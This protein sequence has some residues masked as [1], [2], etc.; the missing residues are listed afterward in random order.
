[1][2][3]LRSIPLLLTG[4]GA[5]T[6]RITRAEEID[7]SFYAEY[8]TV[9]AHPVS[10]L[11]DAASNGVSRN[12][13]G[14]IDRFGTRVADSDMVQIGT[15]TDTFYNEAVGTHPG[16]SLSNST[17]TTPLFQC[18]DSSASVHYLN[19][20]NTTGNERTRLLAL[21]SDG[22][23][24]ELDSAQTVAFGKR[25][26]EDSLKSERLNAFRIGTSTPTNGTWEIWNNSAFKDTT[27]SA[28]TNYHVYRKTGNSTTP[29]LE[30]LLGLMD[31]ADSIDEGSSDIK[32]LEITQQ[33]IALS[34]ATQLARKN[35]ELGKMVLLPSAQ[36]PANTGETGTWQ[37]RGSAIDTVNTT[38]DI[39]Y[40]SEY[41]TS[42]SR[43]EPFVGT[44]QFVNRGSDEYIRYR[45]AVLPDDFVGQRNAPY[46]GSRTNQQNGANEQFAGQ[47]FTSADYAGQRTKE[48]TFVGPR[49]YVNFSKFIGTEQLDYVGTRSY[50][51]NFIGPRVV[52]TQTSY[53]EYKYYVGNRLPDYAQFGGER[54]YG[55]YR[56][57]QM[58]SLGMAPQQFTSYAKFTGWRPFAGTRQLYNI[59]YIGRRYSGPYAGIRQAFRTFGGK[60]NGIGQPITS[61][62]DFA[63]ERQISIREGVEQV[64][65]PDNEQFIGTR[66]FN[67]QRYAGV[68]T[69]DTFVGDRQF[70]KQYVGPR[71]DTFA[72][73]RY[74]NYVGY[75][76]GQYV[77]PYI[78][79]Y[80]GQFSTQYSGATLTNLASVLETYTL[81][82]KVSET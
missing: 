59:Q 46:A 33:F 34:T 9:A 39:Q 23:F 6:R 81:Y 49:Q 78:R 28:Q 52:G 37:T 16:T 48:D 69:P 70:N 67:S 40:T 32:V 66:Q 63:G 45:D 60:R 43:T 51:N 41:Y 1:M 55:G 47:R 62:E 14:S 61:T 64:W 68:V 56:T 75:Y 22:D 35:S 65:G 73:E 30:P 26:L 79:D 57:R 38:E 5:D 44:R 18:Y 3:N 80:I 71:P 12:Y 29:T 58:L 21:D 53:T 19:F 13:H 76:T 24:R 2:S 11:G 15:Y 20:P 7:L 25:L 17:T 10:N 54:D 8:M 74:A 82:C 36:T 4:S 50:T 31:S 42:I 27:S 77:A 72:G